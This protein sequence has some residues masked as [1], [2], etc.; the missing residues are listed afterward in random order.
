MSFAVGFPNAGAITIG[1]KSTTTINAL[2]ESTSE[3]STQ[4]LGEKEGD[5]TQVRTGGGTPAETKADS[6]SNQSIAVKMLLKRMQ[7]LQQQLREQQQQLAATQARSYP[8]PEAK[9]TAVMSIQGQVADTSAALAQVTG[10]L[11]KEL[12]KDSSTG[13]IVSTTA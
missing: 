8:T 10:N 13:S 3:T 9:T 1:G 11:V 12:A 7:E 2:S 6:G 4:L 5:T